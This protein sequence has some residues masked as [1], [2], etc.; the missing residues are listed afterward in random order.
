M[1]LKQSQLRQ[2]I[3]DEKEPGLMNLYH[4]RRNWW[5]AVIVSLGAITGRLINGVC[6][7]DAEHP[8]T[9]ARRR[10]AYRAHDR[11]M[12]IENAYTEHLLLKRDDA[13][14]LAEWRS[15]DFFMVVE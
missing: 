5:W 7:C 8:V 9:A 3:E 12:R 4:H 14:A 1:R 15:R 13:V 10:L 11:A 2:A 6:V